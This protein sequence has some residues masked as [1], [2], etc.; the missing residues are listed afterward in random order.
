M[1]TNPQYN[2]LD[3]ETDPLYEEMRAYAAL[4]PWRLRNGEARIMSA[5]LIRGDDSITQIVNKNKE[6][7]YDLEFQSHLQEMLEN[8][9]GQVVWCH[10]AI[11]DV[12]WCIAQLQPERGGPIP[13]CIKNIHWR[14]TGL[15]IKWLIN[16]QKAEIQKPSMSL[17]GLVKTFMPEHPRAQ[18]FID[19]KA[20][21]FDQVGQ[22][23]E[24]W[25]ER[26]TLDVI[27]TK[28][29][30]CKY[31]EKVPIS[32][33]RGMLT[34]FECIVPLANA[35]LNGIRIDQDQL[36]VCEKYYGNRK[37][38]IAKELSV[39]QGLFSS[40][41]QL[42]QFLFVDLELQPV[43]K[44]PSGNPGTSKG[45]LMWIQRDLL[46]REGENGERY[47]IVSKILEAKES[48]TLYSKYVKTCKEALAHNG[49]GYIYGSPR[50]F[51]TYT[52]RMTYSNA[53]MKKYKTGIALH[54]IP[55]KATMIRAMLC[56][57]DGFKIYE[58]DASGQ[59]SRLMAIRSGDQLMLK[60]FKDGKNFHSMTGSKIVT[61][62]YNEFMEL[63]KAED[64]DGPYTEKRQMGKLTNL[65]CNYR[66]SGKALAKQSFEKYGEFLDDATGNFLV[67]TFKQA[68]TGVEQYWDDVIADSRLS[69]YTEAFGGRRFKLSE[70]STSR[71][72]TE[73]SALSFP[74]QGAGASMKEIAIS[75][76]Y[77]KV[78]EFHFALDLHDA[79]F[80]YIREEDDCE[81]VRAK[82]DEVLDNIDYKAYWGFEPAISLPY[83]S[84]MGESFKDVK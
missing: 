57:H 50:L 13:Q 33:R 43:S 79:T 44:T 63:Y 61:M 20:Q 9:A 62:D 15:L 16:G 4:E 27:M 42:V 30:A 72:V 45:D 84:K 67:R 25:L 23:D 66:I 2:S 21:G 5:D 69:G 83:E 74:I 51:G 54:Q 64:D 22:N 32:M 11:F 38:D 41:K 58:A 78:P 3:L 18:E 17:A 81:A 40:P 34:E 19:F 1:Y 75:E 47:Q 49:D 52:G 68:Y 71:W 8:L 31:T 53:T 65:S 56:P 24:Y 77:R 6:H 35:W 73:S 39:P 12:A 7:S 55:R 82:V 60:V 14:D 46:A 26:G 36:D 48:T 10:N 80:G 70:W 76:L 59:E 29:L 37:R 28:A